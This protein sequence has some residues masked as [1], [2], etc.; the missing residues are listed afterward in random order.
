[1]SIIVTCPN[2]DGTGRRKGSECKIC[3]GSGF[4]ETAPLPGKAAR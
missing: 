3:A 2:C 4:V 1:M